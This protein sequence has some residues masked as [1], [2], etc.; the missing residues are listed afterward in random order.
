MRCNV[1]DDITTTG[2]PISARLLFLSASAAPGSPLAVDREYNRVKAGLQT[3]GVWPAWRV[4]VEHVPAVTWEQ[5]PEQLLL[6]RASIVHF[7]GHGHP[8]SS[9]EFATRAGGA[10]RIGAEGLA[11]LFEGYAAQVRLVVLNACYS[12]ALAAAL[13]EHVDVVIGMTQAISDDAAILF[14]PAF[15]QQLAGGKSVQTACEVASGVVLGQLADGGATLRDLEPSRPERE[16]AQPRDPRAP[17]SEEA[18]LRMR[19]RAGVDASLMRFAVGDLA[20]VPPVSGWGRLAAVIGQPG[21]RWVGV[22]AVVLGL[23]G[24]SLA[25]LA[26]HRVPAADS[27][28]VR[29]HDP[30]AVDRVAHVAG[31]VTLH[32]PDTAVRTRP[33]IE[34]EAVFDDLPPGVAGRAVEVSIEAGPGFASTTERKIVPE[35]RTVR[36]VLARAEVTSVITGTV[37]DA[38]GQPLAGA[39]IDIEHGLVT[40]QTDPRGDFRIVVPLAPGAMVSVV[41]AVDGHVG[42]RDHL[43]VPGTVAVR[44]T[45]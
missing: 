17:A 27:L 16:D 24:A 11:R 44:W 21:V 25:S 35:D 1:A 6:H 41:V 13:V 18:L 40:G 38:A 30:A 10:Q 33:L 20:A 4:A 29:V 34:G 5:V 7:A 19:V 26:S 22:A 39:A 43:T 42:F 2:R 23:L 9:L 37:L 28:V 31:R 45:P 8:D 14:A 36:V 3:L 32:G 12:D 15:Y